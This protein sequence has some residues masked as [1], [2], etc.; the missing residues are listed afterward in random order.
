MRRRDDGQ[1]IGKG[2]ASP[3]EVADY[4]S[5]SRMQV[6]RLMNEGKLSWAKMGRSRRI[7]WEAVEEYAR[8][9]MVGKKVDPTEAKE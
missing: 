1:P 3:D 6:Y 2:Y 4:L 8:S 9:C 7:P 5:M